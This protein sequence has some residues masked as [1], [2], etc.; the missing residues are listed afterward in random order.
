[1]LPEG[2]VWVNTGRLPWLAQ[3]MVLVPMWPGDGMRSTSVHV[4][5][6]PLIISIYLTSGKS[7]HLTHATSADWT[8]QLPLRGVLGS[9]SPLVILWAL[10]SAEP[11][12]STCR[13]VAPTF[14]LLAGLKIA[15]IRPTMPR[16]DGET[17]TPGEGIP[18]GL[19]HFLCE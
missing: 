15:T 11:Q 2:Q 5:S 13:G 4:A 18:E 9:R 14:F 19:T 6:S 16:P 17:V 1:M 12:S 10:K 3:L 8:L 7:L